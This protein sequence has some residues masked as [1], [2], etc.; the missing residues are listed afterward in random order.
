MSALA[1]RALDSLRDYRYEDSLVIISYNE[2]Y[3]D[4]S[5]FNAREQ[6]YEINPISPTPRLVVDGRL[7]WIGVADGYYDTYQPFIDSALAI[8]STFNL[9]MTTVANAGQGSVDLKIVDTDSLLDDS[10][11]AV[12]VICQDGIPGVNKQYNYVAK[13]MFTLPVTV[14]YADTVTTTVTFTHC[15]PVNSLRAVAFIQGYHSRRVLQA[16]AR[17]FNPF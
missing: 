12:I 2:T 9:T 1:E 14:T 15:L 10:L 16:I 7:A 3:G 11:I 6:Y 17:S 13:F 4:T 8:G 5:I